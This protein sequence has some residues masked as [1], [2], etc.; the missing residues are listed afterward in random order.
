MNSFV[1]I[2]VLILVI[3]GIVT[4]FIS[5]FNRIVILKNNVEKSFANIDVILKQ[6]TDEVPNLVRIVKEASDYEKST[7]ESITKLRTNYLNTTKTDKKVELVNQI[8]NK[9]HQIRIAIE[10][11]PDLKANQSYLQL[12]NRL[13]EIENMIA[14]RREF[15]NESVNLYN[16][17]IAIFPDLIF[18]KL[19]RY[20]PMAMLEATSQE[21]Q[22]VK[23]SITNDY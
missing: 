20:Q 7:L 5:T 10:N 23:I 8:D 16:M 18:A 11:Y 1:A 15:Y 19:M 17:G 21:R 9:I 6:R 4:F 3:V 13:S 12:Q 2:L 22:N 14:D